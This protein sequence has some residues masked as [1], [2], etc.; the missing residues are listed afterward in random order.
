VFR[1]GPWPAILLPKLAAAT[2]QA[3]SNVDGN[4]SL[5]W[6]LSLY[7]P[8][9][10][11]AIDWKSGEYRLISRGG[12]IEG[13]GSAGARKKMI[14]MLAEGSVLAAPDEP[15]GNAVDVAPDGFSHP[16]YRSGL[17]LAFKLPS[18]TAPSDLQPV[19]APTDEEALEPRPCA[20]A[21]TPLEAVAGQP[22]VAGSASEAEPAESAAEPA[23]EP[24]E[25]APA[26]PE[27][28]DKQSDEL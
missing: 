7:S 2:A 22:S 1:Q 11:E 24:A 14:R 16:I 13:N 19:E 9:S 6:L 5:Y 12:R 28:S 25:P 4:T 18:V 10:E 8:R 23:S 26:A 27:E 17:A 21:V 15:V 20:E 3:G